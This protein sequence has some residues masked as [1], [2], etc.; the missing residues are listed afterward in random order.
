MPVSPSTDNYTLGK[1]ILYFDQFDALGNLTGERDLGNA[2]ALSFNMTI[3]MLDHFSSRSGLSSKDKQVTK[4]ITPSFKFTL[5]E[6]N[7]ENLGMLFYGNMEDVTQAAVDAA[8]TV[9]PAIVN[10]NLYYDLGA[11]KVGIW[12]VDVIWEVGM[13]AADVPDDS[14]LSNVSGASPTD[15]REA[16][17]ALG[18]RIY[19][20]EAVGTGLS[21]SGDL[22][23]GVTKVATYTV[24][25]AFITGVVLIKENTNWFAPGADFS[26]DA[27]LGRVKIGAA[28]TLVGGGTVHYAVAADTYVRISALKQTKL[29]GKIRF[30]SDNPEGGQYVMSAWKC[31]LKPDGDTAFI[32]EDW[33]TIGF[34]CE[35]LEDSANHPND[36]YIEIIM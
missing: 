6:I 24:A 20:R 23:V 32:G 12:A 9:L 26:V 5:D 36:P 29:E 2:P 18:N 15:Y 1:G 8:T 7:R 34:T 19:L 10:K 11:R 3:D 28:S 21:A 17:H 31:S 4:Q 14:Q 16:I 22:F 27:T 30:I 25:P 33:S 13:S 35:V